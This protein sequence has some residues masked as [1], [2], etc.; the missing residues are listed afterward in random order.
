MSVIK[1]RP[2][3]LYVNEAMQVIV[4]LIILN[5]GVPQDSPMTE[6]YQVGTQRTQAATSDSICTLM[7]VKS[8]PG[9]I[10]IIQQN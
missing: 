10:D 6:V 3:L 1:S 5:L 4:L 8:R 2:A 7:F 9:R